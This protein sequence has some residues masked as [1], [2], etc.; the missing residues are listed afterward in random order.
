M[1][2]LFLAVDGFR[3]QVGVPVESNTLKGPDE[4]L[5][6]LSPSVPTLL[7]VSM[8]CNVLLG[9]AFSIAV[10]ELWRLKSM[11]HAKSINSLRVRL[12]I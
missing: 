1:L 3:L 7:H 2:Y 11:R 12:C 8:K 6:K 10:I 9:V 4:L 5:Y